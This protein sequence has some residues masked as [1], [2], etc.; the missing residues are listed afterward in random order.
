MTAP[1]SIGRPWSSIAFR[2]ALYYG[3]LLLLTM[4]VVLA[5]FYVQ[6]VGVLSNRMD[7]QAKQDLKRLETLS[8][9]YGEAS[10]E[11]EIRNLLNDGVDSQTEIVILTDA[12]GAVLLG[13]ASIQPE[14]SLTTQACASCG[15]SATAAPSPDAWPWRCCPAATCWSWVPTW[16]RCAIS[17][18]V[19]CAPACLRW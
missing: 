13:N 11:L 3:G 17:N 15:C 8:R 10:L 1:S 14:R 18:S 5:I 9:H 6:M 16:K 2:L 7:Q 19:S 4:V 12:H